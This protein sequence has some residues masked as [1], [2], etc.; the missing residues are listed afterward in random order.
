MEL[1]CKFVNNTKYTEVFDNILKNCTYTT[2]NKIIKT[3]RSDYQ[4]YLIAQLGNVIAKASG[5]DVK[6]T[7]SDITKNSITIEYDI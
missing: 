1:N 4:Y 3:L 2:N 6:I 5:K 7:I